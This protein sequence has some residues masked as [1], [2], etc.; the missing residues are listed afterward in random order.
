MSG[1]IDDYI[2]K[3]ESG[4]EIRLRFTIGS[5]LEA[6]RYLSTR[7]LYKL[8]TNIVTNV[9]ETLTLRDTLTLLRFSQTPY[10]KTDKEAIELYEDIL[11]NID[12]KALNIQGLLIN[13]MQAS[14][15]F[16]KPDP[17]S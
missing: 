15:V 6:E 5:L 7:N 16:G 10:L 4:K 14:G 3:T 9:G 12:N 17:N 8:I 2:V 13:A 1:L 11:S